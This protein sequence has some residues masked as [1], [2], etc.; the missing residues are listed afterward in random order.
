MGYMNYQKMIDTIS[1]NSSY[2]H[3]W[4]IPVEFKFYFTLPLF[5]ISFLVADK[6]KGIMGGGF[7]ILAYFISSECIPL[8]YHH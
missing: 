6:I 2:F 3:F 4:T 8:Q 1:F 7:I 5:L